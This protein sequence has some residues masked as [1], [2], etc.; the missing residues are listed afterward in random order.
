LSLSS[1]AVTIK[2]SGH[3][4]YRQRAPPFQISSQTWC[5]FPSQLSFHKICIFIHD[6]PEA[7]TKLP[8]CAEDQQINRFQTP[9][10]QAQD[11]EMEGRRNGSDIADRYGGTFGYKRVE[12]W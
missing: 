2:I 9:Q 10:Q 5:V 11:Q 6:S 4:I 3:F 1:P 8:L 12:I 7:C